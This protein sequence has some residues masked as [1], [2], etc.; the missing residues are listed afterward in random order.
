MLDVNVGE[1]NLKLCVMDSKCHKV[2][3]IAMANKF[4]GFGGFSRFYPY[5]FM[6]PQAIL[7]VDQMKWLL[8]DIM[9]SKKEL[10]QGVDAS[11][12]PFA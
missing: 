9:E 10:F 1:D 6:Q 7:T 4:P 11:D 2:R 8:E 5:A 3:I 12:L